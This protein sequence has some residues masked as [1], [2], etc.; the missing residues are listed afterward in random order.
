MRL[1][2][3]TFVAP[4]AALGA[5][6]SGPG[7]EQRA[8]KSTGRASHFELCDTSWMVNAKASTGECTVAVKRRPVAGG[9]LVAA[10]ETVQNLKQ[11]FDLS[12]ADGI[13]SQC[14]AVYDLEFDDYVNKCKQGYSPHLRTVANEGMEDTGT[15]VYA[16][17]L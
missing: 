16:E 12:F 13:G 10:Y 17:I 1:S 14:V 3:S 6:A 15:Q 4:V 2:A 7:P 11:R 5:R 8:S 9:E